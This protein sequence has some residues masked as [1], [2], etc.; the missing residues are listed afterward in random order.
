MILVVEG[1]GQF[2][3]I[4]SVGED[5]CIYVLKENQGIRH[6]DKSEWGGWRKCDIHWD[7]V[8]QIIILAPYPL[9]PEEIAALIDAEAD[10]RIMADNKI[11]RALEIIVA[12]IEYLR[13]ETKPRQSAFQALIDKLKAYREQT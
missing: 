5:N 6:I 8:N 13:P 9:S 2:R 12:E 4:I 10:K 7:E 11:E 3:K 1:T